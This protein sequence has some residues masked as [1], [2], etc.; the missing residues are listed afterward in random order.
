M[1]DETVNEPEEMEEIGID[2]TTPV[3]IGMGK[4]K[5]KHIK[6]LKKGKGRLMGEV[7][8]VL[9]EI[10]KELGDELDGKVLVPVVIV[11]KEKKKKGS[12]LRLPF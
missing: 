7:V 12:R 3:I 6:R 11:Y 8:D 9:D 10:A 1:N 4:T 5:K 2:V